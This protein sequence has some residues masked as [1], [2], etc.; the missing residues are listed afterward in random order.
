MSHTSTPGTARVP[1]TV[2]GPVPTDRRVLAPDLARGVML[3]VIALA[4]THIFSVMAGG[5]EAVRTVADRIATA[6]TA[7]FV[8]YRGYPMFAAL[9]GYGLAQIHRRRTEQGHEWPW[10]RSLLR[11]RSR[12]MIVFGVVHAALLFFGDILAVYGLLALVFAGVL[13]FRDRTLVVLAVIWL[14]LGA[15]IH[16]LNAADQAMTDGAAFPPVPEGVVSELA[17]RLGAFAFLTPVMF[18]STVVPFLL[19]ILAARHRVLDEPRRHLKLL[20]GAAFVGLPLGLLGGLPLAL[21]KAEA[22]PGHSP[23]DALVAGGLH[24]L[25]GYAAGL[26]YAALIALIAV[27]L[28]GRQGPVANALAALGQ[29]SMTF[30]LAQ[31]VV[32]A[33]LFASYTLHLHV[34]ATAAVGIA[35]AVWST[36]VVLADLMRRR[37]V[38]GPAEAALRRLTYGPSR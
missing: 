37:G 35:V 18:I 5:E 23:L 1:D 38:R 13:R 29:R 22:W 11:R 19:G 20:R 12:W 14:P 3:L 31:S 32:W 17:F 33:A 21:I 6:G 9:F 2:S 30:Y 4:H 24:Q 26:G 8:D 7:V 10:V 16:A 28:H 15:T 36:T 25:S 27:R 34:S